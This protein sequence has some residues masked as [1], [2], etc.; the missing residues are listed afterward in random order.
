MKPRLSTRI[1]LGMISFYRAA[2]SPRLG[3]S[4]RYEPSCSAYAAEAVELFGVLRGGWMAVRRLLRCHPF[5]AG[6]YD[7]VPTVD[8]DVHVS[9]AVSF[10]SR[11]AA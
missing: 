6:G 1:V 10:R 3:P 11:P 7:P 8:R 2:I 9:T 5:H 4:C